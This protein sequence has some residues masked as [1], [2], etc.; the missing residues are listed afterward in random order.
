MCNLPVITSPEQS[1]ACEF[2]NSTATTPPALSKSSSAAIPLPASPHPSNY[3]TFPQIHPA[4]F[5]RNCWN[6]A[7]IS[8]Q[9]APTFTPR[10]NAPKLPEK[11]CSR[12]SA[13]PPAR[14]VETTISK[15]PST[16]IIWSIQQP[17]LWPKPSTAAGPSPPRPVQ[18]SK[19]TKPPFTTTP[20]LLFEPSGKSRPLWPPTS[21]CANRRS[22][23]KK[24]PNKPGWLK[25]EL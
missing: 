16:P 8:R 10:H 7:R 18:P 22:S 24:R 17:H 15:E 14:P 25:N 9:P 19:E 4:D 5:P 12:P 20:G 6:A 11:T 3:P 23:S 13:S 1:A 21:H 2:E